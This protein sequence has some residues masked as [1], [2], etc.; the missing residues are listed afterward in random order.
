[1]KYED[2]INIQIVMWYS[3]KMLVNVISQGSKLLV[4]LTIKT[5]YNFSFKVQQITF[6]TLEKWMSR[7][8]IKCDPASQN[9]ANQTCKV[10]FY[11]Q[12]PSQGTHSVVHTV[13]KYNELNTLT[14]NTSWHHCNRLKGHTVMS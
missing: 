2:T 13:H 7:N 12:Y 14:E 6:F 1:M 5:F 11:Y 3:G 10:S 8:A 4:K 9:Q